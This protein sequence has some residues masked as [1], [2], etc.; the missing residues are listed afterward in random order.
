M[1][2]TGI[3]I[4]NILGASAVDVAINRPVALV[5]GKNYAGKSSVQEAVRM[6]LTGETVRVS[7]K[8]DYGRLV[9][10]GQEVGFAVVEIEDGQAAMT[11]PGGAHERHSALLAANERALPMVLDAQRFAR[12]PDQ[13]RR[14]FLFGLM[15]LSADGPAVR[16]RLEA[17]GCDAKKIEAIMPILRAGFPAACED[18]KAKATAAKGAWRQVTGETYGAKKAIGWKAAK[19]AYDASA[20][21]R[22]YKAMADVELQIVKATEA[23]GDL[24]GYAKRYEEQK[25]RLSELRDRAGHYARIQDKLNRDEAELKQW[26]EKVEET[27]AKAS[28]TTEKPQTFTCPCCGVVLEH[29]LAD[30]ALIEYKAPEQKAD[31][32][33]VEKLPE[34]ERALALMESS[35]AN[36]RRDLAAADAAA[37]ALREIEDA[38]LTDPPD[39]EAITA[40]K[41]LLEDLRQTKTTH[42][43]QIKA[44]EEAA[45]ASAAADKKT[46]DAAQHHADVAAWDLIG[47]ALA[48]DGI[49]GDMLAEALGPIN[50]RIAQS[51]ADTG[52]MTVTIDQ[53]MSLYTAADTESQGIFEHRPYA[54]LSE[55]E[56]WRV[57]AMIAEAVSHL[58]GLK[59]L[60]LDR[61]DVLD[62]QG[63]ADLFAWLDILAANG[64]IDTCLLFGT[65]KTL[66]AEL[67]ATV[68]GHWIEAGVAGKLK[69]AA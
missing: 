2:L 42:Q 68:C 16:A 23:V 69:A 9:T 39:A 54:L 12:L 20:L 57:D 10:E 11:L 60:M 64:E 61:F 34:Y 35:V 3:K 51:A 24:Q 37:K 55:S 26:Q 27:R 65:L 30:G 6:A 13:E 8:K 50:A 46:A 17:K 44:L 14:A 41:R 49:P 31:P 67:P 47:D 66:P 45:R 38:G 36:G 43:S 33:A 48:P 32:D 22:N 40:A 29:R 63:R 58:S 52:W 4:Q 7:L 56:K 53:D 18:A 5:A 19:P 21:D 28:G 59:L 1:K 15:G 62:L 25:G